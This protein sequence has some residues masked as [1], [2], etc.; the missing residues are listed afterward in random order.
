MF[1]GSGV[2]VRWGTRICHNKLPDRKQG[3]TYCWSELSWW[4]TSWPEE[5]SREFGDFEKDVS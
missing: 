2:V 4:M 1:L 3:W 5:I